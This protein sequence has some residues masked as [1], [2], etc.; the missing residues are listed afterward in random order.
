MKE[1]DLTLVGHGRNQVGIESA[2]LLPFWSLQFRHLS[3]V[4]FLVTIGRMQALLSGMNA[5]LFFSVILM[6]Y[7]KGLLCDLLGNAVAPICSAGG[8]VH[9]AHMWYRSALSV[10]C[11]V[12][13]WK[14][15]RRQ[16]VLGRRTL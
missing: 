9:D 3:K 16:E 5:H 11:K 10:L 13:L 8:E 2:L 6:F 4:F 15:R 14:S 12:I 1:R 7:C